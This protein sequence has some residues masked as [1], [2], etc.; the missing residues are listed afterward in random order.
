MCVQY[1]QC[2]EASASA[3]TDEHHKLDTH[4]PAVAVENGFFGC[5]VIYIYI[6]AVAGVEV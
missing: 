5:G 4:S 2:T 6:L 3:L 1:A